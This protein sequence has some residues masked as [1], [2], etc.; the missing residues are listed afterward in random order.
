[1]TFQWESNLIDGGSWA[2]RGPTSPKFLRG[3]VEPF[4]SRHAFSSLVVMR[5]SASSAKRNPGGVDLNQPFVIAGRLG[6]GRVDLD[7]IEHAPYNFS[8][9]ISGYRR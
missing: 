6:K 2:T 8:S 7:A 9:Q 5:F 4:D 3:R 1:M